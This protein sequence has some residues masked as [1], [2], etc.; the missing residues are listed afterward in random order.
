MTKLQL[1]FLSVSTNDFFEITVYRLVLQGCISVRSRVPDFKDTFADGLCLTVYPP[2]LSLSEKSSGDNPI[3]PSCD[4]IPVRS[5]ELLF[6]VCS[7]PY[8]DKISVVS[9]ER[10]DTRILSCAT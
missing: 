10:G 3:Q 2:V 7:P 5:S 8:F 6:G 9:S 4:N 1:L